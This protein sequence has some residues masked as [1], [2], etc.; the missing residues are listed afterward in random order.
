MF[1]TVRRCLYSM[2]LLLGL[3]GIVVALKHSYPT[4]RKFDKLV[5]PS[6]R[7]RLLSSS[8]AIQSTV[9]KTLVDEQSVNACID[10]IS[11]VP[12]KK[13]KVRQHVN[14]LASSFQ[15]PI[16][17]SQDWISASFANLRPNQF[18]VDVGSAKGSWALEMCKHDSSINVLGLEIRSALVENCL[19][20]KEKWN[21]TNVHYLSCNANVNVQHILSELHR[22]GMTVTTVTLQFPDPMYKERHKKR[23]LVNTAFVIALASELSSGAQVFMQSDVKD[24]IEDMVSHFAGSPYFAASPSFDTRTLT[25]NESPFPIKTERE[26]ATLGHG[27]P[28][29]RMMFIRNGEL[30]VS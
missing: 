15:K 1:S 6:L 24:L 30:V 9:V 8:L 12:S 29:Y 27:L 21:L 2:L 25:N 11:S 18:I 28:V 10:A 20:R 7:H 19:M 13:L 3:R 16:T 17:L 22:A 14:P 4:L 23:R 5:V 26:I